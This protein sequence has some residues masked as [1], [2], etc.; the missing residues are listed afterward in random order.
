[1]AVGDF[2]AQD[3]AEPRARGV[4]SELTRR[5]RERAV[6]QLL[7]HAP[8]AAEVLEVDELARGSAGMR[9]QSGGAMRRQRQRAG[10]AQR[11]RLEKP[12]EAERTR[13]IGLEDVARA[14]L[15]HPP[16]VPPVIAVPARRDR[17][18]RGR[19]FADAAQAL[20]IIR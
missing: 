5:G 16:E 19:A 18:A 11:I 2:L 7:L 15:E 6:E 8:V 13:R 1:M 3:E 4:I 20:E 12:G 10:A 9:V 17:Q 14:V